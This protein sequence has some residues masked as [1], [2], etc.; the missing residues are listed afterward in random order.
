MEWDINW[1]IP[2]RGQRKSSRDPPGVLASLNR[3]ESLE[4]R[5]S[6]TTIRKTGQRIPWIET[7]IGNTPRRHFTR[8][9]REL[10]SESESSLSDAR[11]GFW[12]GG[13]VDSFTPQGPKNRMSQGKRT[14][15]RNPRYS[16][17][18]EYLQK[19]K[20]RIDQGRKEKNQENGGR[21]GLVGKRFY[22]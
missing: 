8:N 22:Y 14:N 7:K 4:C 5:P 2:D 13:R 17:C 6:W 18:W 12:N 1:G 11:N 16:E 15:P 10:K 20:E 9:R 3:K 21:V 19:K